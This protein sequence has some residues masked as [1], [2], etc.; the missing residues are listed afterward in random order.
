MIDPVDFTEAPYK[1]IKPLCLPSWANEQYNN[2]R[3]IIAGWGWDGSKWATDLKAVENFIWRNKF[4]KIVMKQTA[5]ESTAITK[6]T[7][8][9][10]ILAPLCFCYFLGS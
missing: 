7:H 8:S 1:N 4:G 10:L 9:I 3:G 6:Y 2:D 5:P